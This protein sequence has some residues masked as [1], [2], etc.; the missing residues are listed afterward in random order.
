MTAT[1]GHL[2]TRCREGRSALTQSEG[3]RLPC[4]RWKRERCTD[5][6]R[7]GCVENCWRVPAIHKSAEPD[8]L[9]GEGSEQGFSTPRLL[10]RTVSGQVRSAECGVGNDTE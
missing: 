9:A 1:V 8:T 10:R 4:R 5:R 2:W 7:S 6:Q 3:W